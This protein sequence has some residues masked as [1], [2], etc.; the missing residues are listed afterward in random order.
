VSPPSP[1]DGNRSRFRN[2]VSYCIYNSGRWTKPSD[3]E[4]YTPPSEPFRFYPISCSV[5]AVYKGI[6][7][8]NFCRQSLSPYTRLQ[9]Q[10]PSNRYVL[11]KLIVGQILKKCIISYETLRFITAPVGLRILNLSHRTAYPFPVPSVQAPKP[12]L[13]SYACYM[14]RP[15]HSPALHNPN[16]IWRGY[17]ITICRKV[18]DYV[19]DYTASHGGRR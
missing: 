2:V 8:S 9:E 14:S 12:S 13:P 5:A 1:E 19:P 3:S 11:E 10:T 18:G 7:P 4:C 17:C 15:C 16:N 6:L